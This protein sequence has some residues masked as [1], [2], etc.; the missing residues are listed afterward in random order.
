MQELFLSLEVQTI[1]YLKRKKKKKLFF[2]CIV[3]FSIMIGQKLINILQQK[4]W[5]YFQLQGKLQAY[6]NVFAVIH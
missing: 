6:M 3:E 4:V 1:F 2:F 5:Q